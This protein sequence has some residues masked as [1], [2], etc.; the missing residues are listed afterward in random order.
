MWHCM[1]QQRGSGSEGIDIAV[2]FFGNGIEREMGEGHAFAGSLL[3][4]R[5][6]QGKSDRWSR[7]VGR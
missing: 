2:V 3:L 7:G 5:S 6:C 4:F 1:G